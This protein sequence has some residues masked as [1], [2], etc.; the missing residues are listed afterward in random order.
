M[1][2]GRMHS[3]AYSAP[4]LVRHGHTGYKQV[5]WERDVYACGVL[6]WELAVG[7]PLPEL[8][9]RPEGRRVHAWL[10]AQAEPGAL[11]QALPPELLEWP[12]WGGEGGPCESCDSNSSPQAWWWSRLAGLAGECLREQ[13]AER[14]SC[15]QLCA[16]LKGLLIA[17][18][19]SG[20]ADGASRHE[21]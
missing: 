3:S 19:K 16:H 1:T 9:S 4:E 13:P 2:I 15:A 21:V 11:A 18:R 8:L 14:P 5:L 7:L 12:H 20:T 17:A 6:L 10:R